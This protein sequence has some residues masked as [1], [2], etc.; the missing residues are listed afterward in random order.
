MLVTRGAQPAGGVA[1]DPSQATLWGLGKTIALEHPELRCLRVDLD[2]ALA[3][4]AARDLLDALLALGG[5][6]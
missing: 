4:D 3:A 5:E 1:P 6:D 2:P